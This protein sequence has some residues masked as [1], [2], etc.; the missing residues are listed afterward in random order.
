MLT[1]IKRRNLPKT[2]PDGLT[3]DGWTAY[4]REMIALFE[5]EE[6]GV[7]PEKPESIRWTE[8]IQRD[9]VGGKA[10]HTLVKLSFDTPAG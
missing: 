6:Y 4:R 7:T 9:N 5:K 8:E 3:K 2:I 1:E 10:V